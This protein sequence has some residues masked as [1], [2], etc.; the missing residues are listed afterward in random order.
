MARHRIGDNDGI[1]RITVCNETKKTTKG[2]SPVL[3]TLCML[4]NFL[5]D[6]DTISMGFL[7]FAL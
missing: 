1:I 4:M 7:I 5:I 2:M 3:L 6:I